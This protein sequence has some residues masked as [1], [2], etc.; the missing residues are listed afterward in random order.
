MLVQGP[1]AFVAGRV[2]VLAWPGQETLA[3]ALAEAADHAAPFPGL[4]PLPPRPITVM[5]ARTRSRFDSLTYHRL[6]AWSSGAAFADA[7]AIVLLSDRPSADLAG[8]LRHELAHLALRWHAG[9][10][11]PLWFEEGY[12]SVAAGEWNRFE[13]LRVNWT[14]AR[15][16][17]FTLDDLDRALRGTAPDAQA[18]YGLATTAVLLLQ[19]WGGRRGLAPLLQAVPGAAS[20]DAALRATYHV[21]EGDFEER[22]Q[23]DL[24]RRYGWLSW[25]AAAG[26]FWGVAALLAAWLVWRRRRTQ[27]PRRAALDAPGELG[28]DAPTP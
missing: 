22:W 7:G 2:T 27:G 16:A 23:A 21:T 11:V 6:P 8:A 24:R 20:F 28:D 15:G 13:A 5:L 9:S 14:V 1:T 3:A 18:A 12:A 25:A 26:V 4:G 19:R 10:R 17:R